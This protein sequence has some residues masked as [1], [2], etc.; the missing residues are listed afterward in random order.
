MKAYCWCQKQRN[1][2][3]HHNCCNKCRIG[4]RWLIKYCVVQNGEC[5]IELSFETLL[6]AL[7]EGITLHFLLLIKQKENK[8]K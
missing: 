6:V 5:S 4:S 1:R 3:F 2:D 7:Q 8:R